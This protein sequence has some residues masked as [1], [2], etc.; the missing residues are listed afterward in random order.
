MKTVHPDA[1]PLVLGKFCVYFLFDE[2]DVLI[3]I[4]SGAGS[5]AAQSY[6]A[7]GAVRA[8]AVWLESEDAVRLLERQM[9]EKFDP[10]LNC[11]LPRA[12]N[13]PGK[14][15]KRNYKPKPVY[16]PPPAIYCK[17]GVE[18]F[19]STARCE[20]CDDETRS[21][22]RRHIIASTFEDIW[23]KANAAQDG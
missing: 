1:V 20:Q 16:V 23:A 5:R 14:W 15:L 10:P 9:I 8:E 17:H 3:Y 13:L 11:V 22:F 19:S 4:G 6:L 21:M 18:K 2:K 7:R 12:G